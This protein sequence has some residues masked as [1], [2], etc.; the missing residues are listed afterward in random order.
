M[1]GETVVP[2][3]QFAAPY[4]RDVVLQA[5]EHESGLRMLRVR[6]REGRRF[7]VM[8]LDPDTAARWGEAMR[9]WAADAAARSP[10]A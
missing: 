3:T 4:G 5:V 7:T 10:A 6:I 8:D 2:L 1:S 9:D